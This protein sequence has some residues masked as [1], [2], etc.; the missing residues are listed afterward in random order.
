MDKNFNLP[1]LQF[2][3]KSEIEVM[4]KEYAERVVAIG[5]PLEVMIAMAATNEFFDK[6]KEQ[7]KAKAIEM[8]DELCGAKSSVEYQ[9]ATIQLKEPAAQYDWKSVPFIVEKEEELKKIKNGAKS[10]TPSSPFIYMVDG[11]I[12]AQIDGVPRKERQADDYTI[13]IILKK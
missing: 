12:L 2:A 1:T 10:A 5:N 11:K 9:G 13:S 4:A 3:T 6:V 7:I 8:A